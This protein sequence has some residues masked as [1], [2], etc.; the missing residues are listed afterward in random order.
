MRT[1]LGEL[2]TACY[3]AALDEVGDE[4]LARRIAAVLAADLLARSRGRQRKR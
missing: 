3:E 1:T 4:R 2:L